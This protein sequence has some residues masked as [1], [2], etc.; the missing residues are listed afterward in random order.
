MHICLW[1]G[2][3]HLATSL[4]NKQ[5]HLAWPRVIVVVCPGMPGCIII[6]CHHYILVDCNRQGVGWFLFFSLSSPPFFTLYFFYFSLAFSVFWLLFPLAL[7]FSRKLQERTLGEREKRETDGQ[8]LCEWDVWPILATSWRTRTRVVYMQYFIS[9]SLSVSV[10]VYAGN[11]LVSCHVD[12]VAAV[13]VH[14]HVHVQCSCS[15]PLGGIGSST[16]R[17]L[18]VVSR[19]WYQRHEVAAGSTREPAEIAGE[20]ERGCREVYKGV[21]N[22]RARDNNFCHEF[23]S[24]IK[25]TIIT[26]ERDRARVKERQR[27]GGEAWVS[28]G[29][30]KVLKSSHKTDKPQI[31]V[32]PGGQQ[33]TV[34]QTNNINK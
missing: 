34:K 33:T 17:L 30:R 8:Q 13:H 14:V 16:T 3:R 26:S 4:C 23:K 6:F 20:R 19:K 21:G 5:L 7:V 31:M 18:P 27:Y 24:W 12:I 15:R 1:R 11:C 10:S 32:M 9:L 22:W 29:S 25:N 28:S 2:G